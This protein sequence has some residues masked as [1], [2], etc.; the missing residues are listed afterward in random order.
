VV[1]LLVLTFQFL[2]LELNST[3]QFVTF[4][5]V[6]LAELSLLNHELGLSCAVFLQERVALMIKFGLLLV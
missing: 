3:L 2:F 1:V 5:V 6:A 4:E